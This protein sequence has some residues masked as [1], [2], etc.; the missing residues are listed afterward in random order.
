MANND[1]ERS[2]L[3]NLTAYVK[4]FE[5]QNSPEELLAIAS[6]ILTFQQKQGIIEI[7]STEAE[8]LVQQVVNGF[9]A[10]AVADSIIDSTTDTLI[11]NVNH[12]KSTLE[13]QVIQVLRAYVQKLPSVE[14][15]NLPDMVSS[16][17]PLV[18]GMQIPKLAFDSLVR[19]VE[20]KFNAQAAIAQIIDP[21]VMAIADK[22]IDSL[23]FSDLEDLVKTSLLG[24]QQLFNH[25]VENITESLVNVQISKIL[26]SNVLQVNIDADAQQLMVKQVT[27]KLNIMQSSSP[28][29]SKSAEE[30]STQ[31]D[32]EIERF[33]ASRKLE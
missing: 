11:Q 18:E 24:D 5:T 31:M 15:A 7:A 30:I 32:S 2:L 13:S 16:I 14:I 27:L 9:N 22:L 23:K 12:W 25:T 10:K 33:K 19:Q 17:L 21:Q 28:A 3:S 29:P 8:E 26:G 1:I 20:S 4:K 6:S